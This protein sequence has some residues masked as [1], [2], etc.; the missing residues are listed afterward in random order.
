MDGGAAMKTYYG[1]GWYMGLKDNWFPFFLSHRVRCAKDTAELIIHMADYI[2]MWWME[3]K[4]N[5]KKTPIRPSFPP[6]NDHNG[7]SQS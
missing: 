1:L 5:S 3:P 4:D 6:S 7:V 2:I